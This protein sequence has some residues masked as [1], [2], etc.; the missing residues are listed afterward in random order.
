MQKAAK[1][2]KIPETREKTRRRRK[3]ENKTWRKGTKSKKYAEGYERNKERKKY[4]TKKC[5]I[6]TKG[7][8]KRE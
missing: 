6:Q 2:R 1:I 4:D 5:V 8:T 3:E 7:R